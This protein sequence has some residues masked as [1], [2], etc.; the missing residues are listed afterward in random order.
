MEAAIERLCHDVT[1][2]LPYLRVPL[3]LDGAPVPS[4]RPAPTFDAHTQEVL[5]EWIGKEAPELARLLASGTV[6]GAP[7]PEGLREFYRQRS[8]R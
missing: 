6:G 8:R 4:R 3:V 7:D 5:R 1:G 2:E